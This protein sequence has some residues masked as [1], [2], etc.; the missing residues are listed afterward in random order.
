MSIERAAPLPLRAPPAPPSVRMPVSI[1]LTIVISYVAFAF[2]SAFSPPALAL[3]GAAITACFL[4]G[5]LPVARFLL[6]PVALLLGL[7]MFTNL[8]DMPLSAT[9]LLPSGYGVGILLGIFLLL[10]LLRRNTSGENLFALWLGM[11]F[12]V[13]AA[14]TT[15]PVP[16]TILLIFQGWLFVMALRSFLPPTS[17]ARLPGADAEARGAR[18][19]VAAGDFTDAGSV[20]SG[21]LEEMQP[22]RPSPGRRGLKTGRL[23]KGVSHSLLRALIAYAGVL[24]VAVILAFVLHSSQRAFN[25]LLSLADTSSFAYPGRATLRSI[26][27]ADCSDRILARVLSSSPP[28]YLA[29]RRYVRFIHNTWEAPGARHP[30]LEMKAGS[31]PGLLPSFQR[32]ILRNSLASNWRPT[33]V[34]RIETAADMTSTF[35]CPDDAQVLGAHL[36]S[37][38]EDD[39]GVVFLPDG[40]HYIGEYAVAR[41]GRR[42]DRV[43][44]PPSVRVACL[45]VPRA[46]ALY[47]APLARE[48][49]RGEHGDL[50]RALAVTT[51]MRTH[52]RYAHAYCFRE[53]DP[54]HEFLVGHAPAHCEFF[55]TAMTLMMRSLGVPARY[56][57]GFLVD[58][59]NDLGGYS[60]VRE[61]FAH[62]WVEVWV[63]G[64]GWVRFD[65][66]PPLGRPQPKRMTTTE[67]WLDLL[68]HYVQQVKDLVHGVGWRQLLSA[69]M[70]GVQAAGRWLIDRPWRIGLLIALFLAESLFRRSDAPGRLWWRRRREGR[71]VGKG[72]GADR[73]L[74]TLLERCDAAM[75]RAGCPRPPTATLHEF[76]A[77]VR[78][79][80]FQASSHSHDGRSGNA[81]GDGTVGP[82]E[83]AV[84]DATREVVVE[85]LELYA[86]AR[87]AVH[88]PVPTVV[89]RLEAL[90]DRL[91]TLVASMGK[92]S[93][94]SRS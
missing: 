41:G 93:R 17:R 35:L 24:L 1:A 80:D 79:F 11:I 7:A 45:Q 42:R 49:T 60:L 84:G 48:A 40:A 32:F 38:T 59:R 62:A 74:G 90:C 55:A 75:A 33:V 89:D 58:E 10:L 54:L 43:S 71:S 20:E 81:V 36:S 8:P 21:A 68:G 53:T 28:V 9:F 94:G 83:S 22:G 37:V 27:D 29:A 13:V 78:A 63:A 56:V 26:L 52:Y 12:M 82:R 69:S 70:R 4:R 39:T 61:N 57:T 47:V 18:E 67:E 87:Y 34:D 76:L 15:D 65:P 5:H 77:R 51:Y 19:E 25:V 50:E 44:L 73:H 46:N 30:V 92:A 85:F 31:S 66:T 14:S 86:F 91:E 23:E 2:V 72:K 64:N 3:L 88:E 16:F 6:F